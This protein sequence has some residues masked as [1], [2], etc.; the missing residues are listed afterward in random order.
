MTIDSYLDSFDL[1]T[2][3][4][5][6]TEVRIG[7]GHAPKALICFGGGSASTTDSAGS[8]DMLCSF[9]AG[10]GPSNRGSI[11]GGIKQGD[12]TTTSSQ[13]FYDYEFCIL[14]D[15]DISLI[16]TEGRFDIQSMNSNG[17]TLVVDDQN[18]ESRILRILSL[19]GSGIVNAEVGTFNSSAS[20]GD[21]DIT[22]LS[23]RPDAVFM[24]AN[25][26]STTGSQA[27][28]VLSIGAAAGKSDIV[29]A[30]SGVFS[31]DDVTTSD[32][33]SYCR[34]GECAIRMGPLG[35]VIK[36]GS[37]TDWLSNGFRINWAEVDG[38]TTDYVFLAIQTA[39]GSGFEIIS[40]TTATNTS[41]FSVECSTVSPSV[42]IVVSCCRAQSSSDT[43]TS[44]TQ[45]SFGAF[46]G[47]STSYSLGFHAL[48]GDTVDMDVG[49]AIDY[50]SVYVNVN[51]SGSIVGEM[52]VTGISGKTIEFTMSNADPSASFFWALV[53]GEV[54][55][56]SSA[57]IFF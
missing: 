6:T 48:G 27:D 32:E 18:T 3:A 8:R 47:T 52:D 28:F 46:T 19:G 20:T 30:V 55:V 56:P 57:P 2:G 17:V 53:G 4:A 1:P 44:D 39:P 36:R 41:P 35:T 26:R 42:G 40:G 31:E 12:F 11:C 14:H 45:I 25:E 50:D 37:V 24:F 29:N 10:T 21:Q 23:F 22:S 38:S 5:T 34:L 13:V 7:Y 33:T 15:S 54:R 9:G 43:P 49:D 16:A 51:A